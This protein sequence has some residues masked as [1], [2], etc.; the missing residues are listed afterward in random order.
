MSIWASAIFVPTCQ[1]PVE[2]HSICYFYNNILKDVNNFCKK[3]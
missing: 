3:N 1:L 2:E